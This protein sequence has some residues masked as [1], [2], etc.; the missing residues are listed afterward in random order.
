M[1]SD[2][3]E[4]RKIRISDFGFEWMV[5]SFLGKKGRILE[6]DNYSLTILNLKCLWD[7]PVEKQWKLYV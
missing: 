2:R 3:P 4:S 6:E 5:L 1:V 7:V